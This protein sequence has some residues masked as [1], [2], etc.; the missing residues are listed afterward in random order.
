MP[1]ARDPAGEPLIELSGYSFQYR[2]QSAPTLH[3]IDLVVRRGEKIAVVGASGSGK[4]TL[5]RPINHLEPVDS[6]L[7]TLDGE[8]IGYR[9]QGQQH[10]AQ[11]GQG[12]AQATLDHQRPSAVV[13]S[14]PRWVTNGLSNA[15]RLHQ[16]WGCIQSGPSEAD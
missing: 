2:A 1:D 7:I 13:T 4:S 12:V 14:P 15:G 3:D 8:V 5:L 6:G 9:R 16:V 10:Q 11:Q